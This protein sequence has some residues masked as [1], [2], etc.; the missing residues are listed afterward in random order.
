MDWRSCQVSGNLS[1]PGRTDADKK[2]IP[3]RRWNC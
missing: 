2:G 3:S 1:I